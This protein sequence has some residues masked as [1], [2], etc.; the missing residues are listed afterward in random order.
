MTR[1]GVGLDAQRHSCIRGSFRVSMFYAMDQYYDNVV[2]RH[3][4]KHAVLQG[5]KRGIH[6]NKGA[7]TLCRNSLFRE[8][9]DNLGRDVQEEDGG[10]ERE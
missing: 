4:R 2:G 3:T 9:L 5:D 10:N 8:A 1:N 7:T 6:P